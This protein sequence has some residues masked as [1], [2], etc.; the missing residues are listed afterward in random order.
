MINPNL[1]F[2]SISVKQYDPALF[3]EKIE[4]SLENVVN[5]VMQAGKTSL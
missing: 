2:Y 1:K 4:R 5:G 3:L